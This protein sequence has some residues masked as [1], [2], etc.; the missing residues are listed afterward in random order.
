MRK[1]N[2]IF[3]EV[4]VGVF[5]V[6]VL[7][8]LAYFTI[9]ISGVDLL[10]GRAMTTA[11]VEFPDVGG[12]KERDSV[13][14][15]GMKVGT[16]DS[17]ALAPK[18]IT[19]KIKVAKEVVLRKSYRIT[20]ASH[21]LL[22]GNFLQLDEGLGDSLP[23]E[24]TLFRGEPPLDWM[25][26][27]GEIARNLS[28]ITKDGGI[29]G[30]ITNLSTASEK[31]NVM[32]QRVERG[33]GTVGRL[34]SADDTL[35]RDLQD[36]VSGAKATFTNIA[37]VAER[38]ERGEGTIGK[39]LSSDDTVYV[40][41]KNTIAKA[42]EIADR[43][44]A[45]EGTIGKL[46]SKDSAVYDDLKASIANIRDVTGKI[47]E[48]DGLLAR[49]TNDKKLSD[50]A[51]ALFDNLKTISDR[52]QKGEGTLGRLTTDAELYNEISAL[53]KDVR[54]IVDNYRDTTPISTFAGLIGGAL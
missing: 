38:V 7:S 42:S 9:V 17:I 26:D 21:S 51:A 50:D 43:L 18:S 53:L 40:D 20:V 52:L 10:L 44:A 23:L 19:V 37:V 3:S 27:L 22:G 36:A 41:L 28:D 31:V 4:I 54:Q 39:L 8:L 14:Y 12:L 13:V 1:S 33:E 49:I 29:K 35:Y 2:D 34:L 6:A 45:G 32:V 30:I 15:R 11:V 25:R 47:K 48:G 5:M 46:L 16:V 24:T